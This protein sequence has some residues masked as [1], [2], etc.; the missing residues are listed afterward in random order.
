MATR[1]TAMIV[2]FAMV[3]ASAVSAAPPSSVTEGSAAGSGE[4]LSTKLN[5][6][7]GVIKPQADVDPGIHVGAPEPHPNST[8]VVPPAVTGGGTA[9]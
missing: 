1:I 5:K 3:S 6:S 7:D 2:G 8:P 9:K 4:S